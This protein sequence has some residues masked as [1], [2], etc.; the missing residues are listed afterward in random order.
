MTSA[1]TVWP[2][3]TKKVTAPTGPALKIYHFKQLKQ[4]RNLSVMVKKLFEQ[5]DINTK[6]MWESDLESTSTC[7]QMEGTKIPDLMQEIEELFL[8]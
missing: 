6:E 2:S 3:Q 5:I 4:E 8:T 7:I 1:Q